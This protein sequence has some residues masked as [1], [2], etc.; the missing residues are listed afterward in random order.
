MA[1]PDKRVIIEFVKVGAYVKVSAID[2]LTRVEVSIVGDPSMSQ[3]TLERTALQKLN[4]V[5]NKRK[6]I[7]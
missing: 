3:T 7:D 4:Y 5:L 1:A 6:K 2:P